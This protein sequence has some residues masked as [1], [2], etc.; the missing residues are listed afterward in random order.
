MK[1]IEYDLWVSVICW[2][3]GLYIFIWK[4]KAF[5]R[6]VYTPFVPSMIVVSGL[7]YWAVLIL[8]SSGA[9]YHHPQF[10]DQ[11]QWEGTWGYT[12]GRLMNAICWA[13][14]MVY[15]AIRSAKCQKESNFDL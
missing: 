15:I 3:A 6:R 8:V 4:L 11:A 14:M 9:I 13:W 12:F 1:P 7:L 10:L 2:L 5:D